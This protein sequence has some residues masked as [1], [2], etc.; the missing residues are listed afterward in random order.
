MPYSTIDLVRYTINTD[1]SLTTGKTG[2]KGDH[3]IS[4]QPGFQKELV[5]THASICLP[6]F[7]N[8]M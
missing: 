6:C 4:T 5:I 2:N 8:S 7:Y 3:L 1:S